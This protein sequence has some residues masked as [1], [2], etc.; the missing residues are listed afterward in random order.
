MFLRLF[1]AHRFAISIR[2]Q[3]RMLPLLPPNQRQSKSHELKRSKFIDGTPTSQ[4][5]SRTCK[6]TK[7]IWIR[8]RP[9]Y[10][11]RCWWLKMRSIQR[12]HSGD[13]VV[14]AFVV[15]AQWILAARIRWR[16]LA[17]LTRIWVNHVKF[18]HCRTCMWCV[19]WYRTWATSTNNI[20]QFSRGCNESES[21]F[22]LS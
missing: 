5:K 11:M 19:I 4:T 2:H 12:W 1:F 15:R 20:H 21:L 13:R 8:V 3:Q 9:W 6:S 7:S 22:S 18:I 16:V 14:R 10:W 17:K